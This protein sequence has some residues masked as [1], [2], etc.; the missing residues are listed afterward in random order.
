MIHFPNTSFANTE[1]D[2]F[3][4][5]YSLLRGDTTPDHVSNTRNCNAGQRLP[6]GPPALGKG[7]VV[8]VMVGA[9]SGLR[10]GPWYLRWWAVGP[11]S[12]RGRGTCSGGHARA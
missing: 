5:Q 12:G 11:A 1:R 3:D 6:R 2:R 4:F 9:R 8:P 7:A 10:E